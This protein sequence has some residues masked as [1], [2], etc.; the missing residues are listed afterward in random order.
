MEEKAHGC[1]APFFHHYWVASWAVVTIRREMAL[2]VLLELLHQYTK[3]SLMTLGKNYRYW[4]IIYI[5][6]LSFSSHKVLLI[7]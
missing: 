5:I 4:T 2:Y 1:A 7:K 3:Y 6:K